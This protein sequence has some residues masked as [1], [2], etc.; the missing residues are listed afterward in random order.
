MVV[1]QGLRA[2]TQHPLGQAQPAGEVVEVAR[3]K[4]EVER[5]EAVAGVG[6][7]RLTREPGPCRLEPGDERLLPGPQRLQVGLGRR[8]LPAQGGRLCLGLV[9]RSVRDHRRPLGAHEL[10]VERRE[11]VP[12]RVGR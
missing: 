2:L 10:L 5:A 9:L 1:A 6:S 7:Q 8:E 3:L 4:H 11:Q 12:R